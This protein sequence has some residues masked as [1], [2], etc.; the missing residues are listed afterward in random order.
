MQSKPDIFEILERVHNGEYCSAKDWDIKKINRTIR[1]ILQAYNLEKVCDP[2]NPV[3]CDFDMA[4]RFFEAGFAAA[5]ELGYWCEDTERIVK[6]SQDELE[7]ALH[8]APSEIFFGEGTDGTLMKSRTPGDPY[9]CK[10]TASLGITVS[11]EIALQVLTGIAAEREVDILEGITLT[12]IRGHQ[13]L[14]GTPWETLMGYEYGRM[15]REARRLAGRPGMA[16][17]GSISATTEFGQFG[18]YGTPGGF[19][20]KTDL[21][22][23]LFPSEMK[24][25]YR[26]LNKVVHTLNMGGYVKAD[27]PSMI[28]GMPGPVEGAVVCEIACSLLSYPILQNHAGGGQMYDVRYLSNVNR[29]GLWGLSVVNQALSR[30]THTLPVNI[31]NIASGP[32]TKNVL[33]EIAAGQATIA[34]SG[35][36]A[37]IGPRTAGGKLNDYI[38]PLECR[39]TGEVTHACSHLSPEVV[40]EIVKQIVPL[41]EDKLKSPEIGKPYQ[42][43]YDVATGLPTEEWESI[44]MDVRQ[45]MIDLGIPLTSWKRAQPNRL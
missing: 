33:Y 34:C 8:Y 15:H 7:A 22:L 19:N 26:T 12:S 5:L 35:A 38:T 25:D 20:P 42:Q 21:S 23:I 3:N 11:E 36:S 2:A 32:V 28:G 39:F 14:T 40:N 45:E 31:A 1:R 24:I 17:W 29:E 4:D 6:V 44:Y 37:T 27:S 9:P 43:A 30:N 18:A 13:V 16:G 41:Y 10:V